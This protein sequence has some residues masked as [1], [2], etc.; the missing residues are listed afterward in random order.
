MV[1]LVL[2]ALVAG[3]FIILA[4][5]YKVPRRTVDWIIGCMAAPFVVYAIYLQIQIFLLDR[6]A[7]D[8]VK[9]AAERAR[10]HEWKQKIE[11]IADNTDMTGCDLNFDELL[12]Y[13]TD[14]FIE[15]VIQELRKMP[16]GRR[17]LRNAFEIVDNSPEQKKT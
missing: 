10:A 1:R 8:P 4:I 16:A 6:K 3:P 14:E 12:N 15:Q 17:N 7:N 13:C 5:Y 11:S 2:T 9:L